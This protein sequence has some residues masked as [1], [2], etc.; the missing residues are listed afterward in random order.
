MPPH[1]DDAI[2]I[3]RYVENIDDLKVSKSYIFIT[4]SEG[5]TYKR[6]DKI[7]EDLLY[8]SAD[9]PFY[10]PYTIKAEDLLEIW[11]YS[12]SIAKK[13]FDRI[14]FNLDNQSI[15]KMFEE[16]KRDIRMLKN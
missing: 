8:I 2:I 11:E 13:E 15:L 14:D 4:Y 6:L 5:M 3:G 16:I 12:C 10:E 7:E 1:K 9:N